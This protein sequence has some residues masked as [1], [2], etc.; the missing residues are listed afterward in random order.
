MALSAEAPVIAVSNDVIA[1][2]ANAVEVTPILFDEETKAVSS[3]AVD[4]NRAVVAPYAL[5]APVP[6]V[7][8]REAVAVFREAATVGT[9][10]LILRA[11][12]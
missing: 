6:L 3:L 4:P 8:V 10:V 2:P 1:I 7:A 11:I 5:L 9:Q 12:V